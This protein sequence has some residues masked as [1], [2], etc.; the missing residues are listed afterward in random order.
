MRAPRKPDRGVSLI[1]AMVAL[2]VMA[3]GTLAVLG[4]QTTLRLNADIAQQRNEAV[5]IAQQTLEE[6]RA[7]GTL[8]GYQALAPLAREVEGVSTTFDVVQTVIDAEAEAADVAPAPVA[9]RKTVVVDVNWTDRAG[10]PQGVRLSSTVQGTPP[11]LPGS[12]TVAANAAV[13]R[14][15][16]GRH[17]AIPKGAIPF[18]EG[19][20]KFTPPASDGIGWVFNN[21]SGVITQR[22]TGETPDTCV[23][24]NARLLAGYLRF[25]TDGVQ[26]TGVES[27]IPPSAKLLFPLQVEVVQTQPAAAIVECYED[28]GAAAYVAYFCAVPVGEAGAWSGR[29]RVAGLPLAV[30]ILDGDLGEYKVCR[31]TPYQEH[32]TVPD[33]MRNDQHPLDYVGV[34]RTLLNQNFLIIRAGAGD[35]DPYGCPGDGPSP[36]ID[37]TT[38]HHQPSS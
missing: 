25:A 24:F 28:Q 29:S 10:Q 35:I 32:R 36:Y 14:N 12:L 5:R 30:R 18:G 2:A 3:F 15:P 9:R 8:A 1:E 6:A 11:E 27:E 23:A 26:P 21:L 16:G 34:T 20:S 7:F 33:G 17:P 19:S 37:G 4:V 13:T 22:C 38:W 31:Y